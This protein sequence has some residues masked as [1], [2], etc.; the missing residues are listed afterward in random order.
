MTLD[1]DGKIRM[2]CSSPYAMASLVG[3]ASD[4]VRH[5]HRQR[6]R[7]R[8]A[9]HR[10]ARRRPDEPEPLP[11]RRDLL[12]LRRR[13]ARLAGR[14]RDRQD[15]GVVVDDRPGRRRP[16]PH[17]CSRC[18]SGSS[19]SCPGCSTASVGFGGEESAGASFLRTDG[20]VWTTDKDG[21]LLA[22]LASE[23]LAMT[24]K[25]PSQHYAELVARFGDPAYARVDAAAT[26]EEKAALGEALARRRSPPTTLA[27]EPITAKLTDGAR[28][29]R[30]DR[31]PQGDRPRT[32]GSPPGRPA[33][34]T[35]TRSTPSRSAA[36]APGRRCRPRRRTSSA[37]R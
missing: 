33:P 19:G 26:R 8:P 32:R 12:P 14:H 21:I 6:R 30:G 23:I 34:R 37:P 25:T 17:G 1:W 9:R 3:A 4:A 31:R 28:Q 5:R 36:G 20:T 7:R 15:A 22:L 18:R 29:R 27:G 35:S 11:R 16:R 10:H 2:D 24:G 13:A